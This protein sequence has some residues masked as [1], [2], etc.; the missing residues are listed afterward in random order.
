MAWIDT[1]GLG[2]MVEENGELAK[3]YIQS[4]DYNIYPTLF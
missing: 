2:S 1:P 4:A 3:E